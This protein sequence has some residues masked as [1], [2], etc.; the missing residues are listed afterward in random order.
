MNEY[1]ERGPNKSILS[2]WWLIIV[3]EEIV[4][5]DKIGKY[6]CELVNATI[7]YILWFIWWWWWWLLLVQSI[8]LSQTIC[9]KTTSK[10]VLKQGTRTRT[11]TRLTQQSSKNISCPLLSLNIVSPVMCMSTKAHLCN[12]MLLHT[13][14]PYQMCSN[15]TSFKQQQYNESFCSTITT[16]SHNVIYSHILLCILFY[17]I[18]CENILNSPKSKLF[19]ENFNNHEPPPAHFWLKEEKLV[20]FG[21]DTL[22]HTM[23]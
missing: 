2:C 15:I 22:I 20:S 13:H 9:D 14:K 1:W 23:P 19:N 11:Q 17:D 12:F 4:R 18:T 3:S 16:S 21:C 5:C 8:F 6:L 7:T 10:D